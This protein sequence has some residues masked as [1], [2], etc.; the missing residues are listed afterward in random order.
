MESHEWTTD[1]R[2]HPPLLVTPPYRA[3][4]CTRVKKGRSHQSQLS[5]QT[6]RGKDKSCCHIYVYWYCTEERPSY[7]NVSRRC[8]VGS[9]RILS[10]RPERVFQ[11]DPLRP[12]TAWDIRRLDFGLKQSKHAQREFVYVAFGIAWTTPR[13]TVYI[14]DVCLSILPVL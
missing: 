11:R 1:F 6:P 13:T 2:N 3:P 4:T 12:T 14:C 10:C 9:C 7:C 5:A 8:R